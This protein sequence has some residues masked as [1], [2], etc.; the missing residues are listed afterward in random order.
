M[1]S[2]AVA[3]QHGN[4]GAGRTRFPSVNAL[5]E[6]SHNQGQ[7]RTSRHR[8]PAPPGATAPPPATDQPL[9]TSPNGAVCHFHDSVIGPEN[10]SIGTI[11]QQNGYGTSWFGKNHNTPSY[12]YSAA[13]PYDQW[14][15][16]MGFEYF[17][18]FMG[19]ETDQWT[20]YLFQN[21]TQISPWI[22]KPGYNLTTDMA[23][24]AIAH[25]QRLNAAAP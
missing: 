17:Y 8:C 15:T 20:P 10:A 3:R 11:L 7:G 21:T 2:R 19:G 5:L 12:Q 6:F 18:G 22:G 23:D 16:G 9:D 1:S 24:E 4:R 13:G 14:P 25:I